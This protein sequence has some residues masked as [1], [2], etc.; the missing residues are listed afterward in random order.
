M[1]RGHHPTTRVTEASPLPP[2][3]ADT[4]VL[5]LVAHLQSRAMLFQLC[6]HWPHLSPLVDKAVPCGCCSNRILHRQANGLPISSQAR[7]RKDRRQPCVS[8]IWMISLPDSG[9]S[10]E[11]WLLQVP[12]VSPGN[13]FPVSLQ[14]REGQMSSQH[15]NCGLTEESV[16]IHCRRDLCAA[17]TAS[18][19]DR[20]LRGRTS[21]HPG[22]GVVT[23]LLRNS[24]ALETPE[25]GLSQTE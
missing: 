1:P 16:T 5:G 2:P 18:V 17:Q 14:G 13:H 9:A 4:P 21:L 8:V 7:C 10:L 3:R 25:K 23:P 20:S 24:T 22:A 12:D 6:V 19:N 11:V 15:V